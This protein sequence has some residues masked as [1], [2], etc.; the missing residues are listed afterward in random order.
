M[1]YINCNK[2]EKG[3]VSFRATKTRNDYN[4]VNH[5]DSDDFDELKT[6]CTM[7]KIR[8]SFYVNNG[9]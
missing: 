9:Y 3:I 6:S 2:S 8:F 5:V 1:C 4:K 7:S